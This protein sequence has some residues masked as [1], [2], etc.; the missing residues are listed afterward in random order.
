MKITLRALRNIIQ[1]SLF[2]QAWVPGRYYPGSEE[3]SPD[4][5][6]RL[7]SQLGESDDDDD[8]LSI[9][10]EVDLDPSNNPGRPSD[11][12]EYVGMKPP[13]T[14]AMAHPGASGGGGGGGA[15]GG[16]DSGGVPE[17]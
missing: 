3:L 4:D 8:E 16:S 11:A 6:D 10:N 9:T 13:P 17:E 1:E 12:Y 15:S 2:E 5:Q 14:A 7:N